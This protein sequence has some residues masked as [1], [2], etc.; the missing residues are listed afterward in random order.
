MVS[1]M[2]CFFA[3]AMSLMTCVNANAGRENTQTYLDSFRPT[4]VQYASDPLSFYQGVTITPQVPSIVAKQAITSCT[5]APALPSGLTLDNL[6]CK[7][8]GTPTAVQVATPYTITAAN[9]TGS[10]SVQVNIVIAT[11]P[12]SNLV[13]SGSPFAFVKSKAITTITPTFTSTVTSCTASPSLPGLTLDNTT[14]AI[15]GT[16]TTSQLQTTHTITASNAF[17]STSTTIALTVFR[18][19]FVSNGSIAGSSITNSSVADNLCNSDASKPASTGSYKAMIAGWGTRRACTSGNCATSGAAENLDWVLAPNTEYRRNDLA[20]KIMTTNSA[21]IF[22]F[23]ALSATLVAL[24]LPGGSP[25]GY[26]SGM[27]STWVTQG[28]SG[29]CGGSW[30]TPLGTGAYGVITA[31][32]S[33]A[34]FSGTGGNCNSTSSYLVCAQQ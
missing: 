12:P 9:D 10:L 2:L 5:S 11:P 3:I 17:G 29:T 26:W 30:S 23:G 27:G 15:S 31:T 19:L 13:Y 4:L 6:T 14:C 21:G 24:P 1:R 16:P 22:A 7:I 18:V 8:S 32:N 25:T 28:A 33:T 34:L 20:T